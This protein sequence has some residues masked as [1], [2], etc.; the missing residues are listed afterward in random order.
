[1]S[2]IREM[3]VRGMIVERVIMRIVRITEVR[4]LG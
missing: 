1:M 4:I 3:I 2:T